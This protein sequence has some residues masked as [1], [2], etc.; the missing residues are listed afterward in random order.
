M[1][2]DGT[3]LLWVAAQVP[4]AETQSEMVAM[5]PTGRVRL[6]RAPHIRYR[7][8]LSGGVRPMD[9]AIEYFRPEPKRTV[10]PPVRAVANVRESI[11]GPPRRFSVGFSA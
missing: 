11:W 8:L 10:I 9:K 6:S 3:S 2:P 5:E 1:P 7:Y 4:G